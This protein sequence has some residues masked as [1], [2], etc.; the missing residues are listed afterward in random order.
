MYAQDRLGIKFKAFNVARKLRYGI[1]SVRL[2]GSE[3]L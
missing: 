2:F 3:E 1:V